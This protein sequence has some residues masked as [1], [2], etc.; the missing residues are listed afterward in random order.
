MESI[1]RSERA[2]QL[3]IDP[4]ASIAQA[5]Q[6]LNDTGFGILLVCGPDGR[7]LAS[8]TDGDVRRALLKN[9]SLENSTFSIGNTNPLVGSPIV[10]PKEALHL[11]DHGLPFPV[12]HL[13]IVE[14][15]GIVCDLLVRRDF[16]ASDAVPLSAVVMAGGAGERL[17]PLTEDTPKPMLQVG[18]KPLLERTIDHLREVGIQEVILTTHHKEQVIID[19]FGNGEGHGLQIDYVQEEQPLGTAGALSNLDLEAD[20][21]LVLNGDVLTNIDFR[22][23]LDFHQRN[24]ADATIAVRTH[25]VQL[26]YGV[27]ETDN[28]KVIGLEEKPKKNFLINAG[29]YLL[30]TKCLSLIPK[31]TRFDM[32]DLIQLLL[33]AGCEVVCFP[34]IEY[35]LDIGHQQEYHQAQKDIDHIHLQ[36]RNLT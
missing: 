11:M 27:I 31:N 2:S 29:I 4:E 23:L 13:P 14:D 24:G 5:I 30:N 10:S 25:E 19:H 6:K 26:Q 8:L 22:A 32:T 16:V 35:W 20:P 3:T 7:L 15:D 17:M 33:G 12:N 21:I 18:G 36:R 1:P 9:I 34:I 28:H